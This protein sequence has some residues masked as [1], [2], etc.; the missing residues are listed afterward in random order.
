ML[1]FRLRTSFRMLTIRSVCTEASNLLLISAAA[2]AD[3]TSSKLLLL[4]DEGLEK[5]AIMNEARVRA[6]FSFSLGLRHVFMGSALQLQIEYLYLTCW[7]ATANGF[8]AT[9][10]LLI[11]IVVRPVVVVELKLK[12]FVERRHGRKALD[13]ASLFWLLTSSPNFLDNSLYFFAR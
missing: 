13:S 11:S 6:P 10:M 3:D 5:G 8:T 9:P 1:E 2:A 4:L 7:P 12:L